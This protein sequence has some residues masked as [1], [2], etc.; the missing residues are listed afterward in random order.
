[1]AKA[2]ALLSA[3]SAH[4]WLNCTAAPRLEETIPDTEVSIYA[5]EGTLAHSICE[6]VADYNFGIIKRPAFRKRLDELKHDPLYDPEMDKTSE[7]YGNYLWEKAMTYPERPFVAMEVKVEL[8]DWIPDGF[9]TCDC[10]MIGSGKLHI[11][12][13]K[14][15][16]GVV[17]SA[18]NNP[19]MRLYALGALKK[20]TAIFGETIQTVSMAIV[21]PRITED[22][23]EEELTVEE[24]LAWGEQIKPIA[25]KAF[26]GTGA[27]YQAGTWCKF[28]KARAV[29][30]A[31]SENMTALED[32]KDIV[33]E[34]KLSEDD[35]KAIQTKELLTGEKT[36]TLTDAEV[37]DLIC[38][39]AALKDWY[40]DLCSYAQQ[41]IEA[42][43]TIPGYK[44]VAGK[45]NREWTDEEK[46][47]KT[48]IA[49]GYAETML[50]ERKT[51]TLSA[52]EKMI[53]KKDFEALVGQYITKPLGKPTLV[54]ASDKRP[55]Y[56][57]AKRDFEALAKEAANGKTGD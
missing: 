40:E 24:L 6:A 36:P 9:G 56:S 15:G 49:G 27:T 57:D 3:S 16:K 51:K 44:L 48:I 42:G 45:S 5:Q 31:R 21:Q 12:D 2:H 55:D 38:R 53:G 32:F 52:L 54:S 19:Q 14:H 18:Q 28:C 46:A 8:T 20:Y 4:R 13:Y 39:G 35:R 47:L 25:E 22:V 41:A 50:Y 29:C 33:I 7:F 23:E 10:V 26:T 17:V 1:M 34:G 43:R 37:A 11:T 30:R